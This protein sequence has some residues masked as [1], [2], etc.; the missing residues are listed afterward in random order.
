MPSD[1][2]V[3]LPQEE[4]P[5]PC[6]WCDVYNPEC[7]ICLTAHD[8]WRKPVAPSPSGAGAP[9]EC[10]TLCDGTYHA[11][12]CP[13]RASSGGAPP[14][15]DVTLDSPNW[16]QD[17][18]AA[19]AARGFKRIN[20]PRGASSGG[21]PAGELTPGYW[22]ANARVHLQHIA[23][24][25]S[26]AEVERRQKFAIE[27]ITNAAARLSGSVSPPPSGEERPALTREE[28]PE[29]TCERCGGPNVVW[30]APSELWN[31]VVPDRDAIW[32]PICFVREAER[33]G[34]L[35][36]SWQLAP[37][38]LPASS[39]SSVPSETG[40]T[41]RLRDALAKYGR[42]FDDCRTVRQTGT[43]P[44]DDCTCGFNATLSPTEEE[45]R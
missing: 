35:P 23:W 32:C 7:A 6:L 28:H 43:Y 3:P 18:R 37:E 24:P 13:R 36:T 21:A 5:R 44:P 38:V 12:L 10:S 42:H 8:D 34:I 22:L 20:D 15:D 16:A 19:L 26:A 30:F 11:P 39:S 40:E 14:A 33:L 17:D 4:A 1:P 9:A 41:A 25:Y 2:R 31:R 27:C 29:A 45:P